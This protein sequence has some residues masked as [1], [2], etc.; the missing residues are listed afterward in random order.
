MLVLAAHRIDLVSRQRRVA[1]ASAVTGARFSSS[2]H[3]KVPEE[4]GAAMEAP[5]RTAPL[6]ILPNISSSGLGQEIVVAA[7]SDRSLDVFGS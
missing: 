5:F 3:G 1:I 2:D 7:F 4:V 6:E